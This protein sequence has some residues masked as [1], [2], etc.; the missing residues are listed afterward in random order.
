M[1]SQ[2]HETLR[3]LFRDAD[4]AP[5]P[6]DIAPVPALSELPSGR[7]LRVIDG[8]AGETVEV[9]SPDGV[10][11]LR[12]RLTDDGPVLEFEAARIDLRASHDVNVECER[13]SVRAREDMQL[14]SAEDI[15]IDG[16]NVLINCGDR[17][18]PKCR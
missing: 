16:D 5:A 14:R 12:V 15:H 3:A 4:D 13:F 18:V 9:R 8:R 11:E 6:E 7:Q 17:P 2:D 1:P 10:V